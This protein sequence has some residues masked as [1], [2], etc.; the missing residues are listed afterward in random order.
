MVTGAFFEFRRRIIRLYK[1]DLVVMMVTYRVSDKLVDSASV[2]ESEKLLLSIIV[3]WVRVITQGRVLGS[4]FGL[5]GDGLCS[6]LCLCAGEG[7]VQV[8]VRDFFCR[9]VVP[10]VTLQFLFSLCLCHV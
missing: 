5:G 2:G 7:K 4:I 9:R 6:R 1:F 10:W 8:D 3:P